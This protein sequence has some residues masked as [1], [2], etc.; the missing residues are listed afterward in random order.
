[1]ARQA[2]RTPVRLSVV[3]VLALAASR[4]D[5]Q[6]P[7]GPWQRYDFEHPTARWTLAGRLREVSGLAFGPDGGLFAHED[8]RGIVYRL[9][10][11]TG[12]ADRGFTL[13]ERPV[14]GDFEG[15]AV[16][17]DRFFLVTSRG[18][19]YEFRE[20]PAGT[21]TSYRVTDTGLGSH[22]EVEGLAYDART[23]R[24]LLACKTLAP[25]AREIRIHALPL[26]P[27]RPA[28]APLVVPFQA[29]APFGL[30]KGVHPSGLEVD[31]D[32]GELILVA[33][34]EEA[35]VVLARDGTVVG[36]TRFPRGEHRQ[37]E[38]VAVS[39][40]GGLYV[41]DEAAGHR[42]RLTLYAPRRDGP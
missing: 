33:A 13:G 9:D 1:M 19:L 3:T 24:L 26:E 17:G 6:R 32:T 36:A 2:L 39:P 34:R 25:P 16:A 14:K 7:L 23:D 30:G 18:L 15:I 27:G 11:G 5:G 10:P 35:L 21:A 4:A 22:C 37:A 41:A 31:G 8:E 20:S 29:L 38:G 42:P 40:D 28:P 12:D